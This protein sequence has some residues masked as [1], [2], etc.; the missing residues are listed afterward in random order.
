MR[1]GPGGAEFERIVGSGFE[2]QR[3]SLQE[4]FVKLVGEDAAA[5]EL[6]EQGG[7]R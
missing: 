2:L 4:I 3:P 7:V 5:P 1:I 6:V